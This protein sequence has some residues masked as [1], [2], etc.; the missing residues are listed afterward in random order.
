VS[1]KK[2]FSI[3]FIVIIV[4]ASAFYINQEMSKRAL[5]EQISDFESSIISY[6]FVSI[7]EYSANRTY[8]SRVKVGDRTDITVH[9]NSNYFLEMYVNG[10]LFK[11]GMGETA[12][13]NNGNNSILIF[14]DK[15]GF[16]TQESFVFKF[17]EEDGYYFLRIG[18]TNYTEYKMQKI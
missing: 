3:I 2:L 18:T 5:E 8:G 6:D 10:I 14:A 12:Y 16:V 7:S 9:I 1:N 13:Y 15:V 11:S 17:Y 4:V